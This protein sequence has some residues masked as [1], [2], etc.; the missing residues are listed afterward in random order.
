MKIPS[1]QYACMLNITG[2]IFKVKLIIKYIF[3][4]TL[5]CFFFKCFFYLYCIGAH[6][7]HSFSLKIR[8]Q[9]ERLGSLLLP[10]RSQELSFQA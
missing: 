9:L 5:G 4:W 2:I 1:S 6:T 10:F 3:H 7:Y 8:E